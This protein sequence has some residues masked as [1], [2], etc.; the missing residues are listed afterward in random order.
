[1]WFNP[2]DT[3]TYPYCVH[4]VFCKNCLS[5]ST[6]ELSSSTTPVTET[7]EVTEVEESEPAIEVEVMEPRRSGRNKKQTQFFGNPLLY[8][9]T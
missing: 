8:R 7:E 6:I 5:T 3:L 4:A 2:F 9:V 1:M